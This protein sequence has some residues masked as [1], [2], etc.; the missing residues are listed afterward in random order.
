[1]PAVSEN[2]IS[3]IGGGPAGAVTASLLARKGFDVIVYEAGNRLG[4]KPCGKGIPSIGD[5]PV[6]VPQ[7][8]IVRKISGAELYVDGIK[9]FNIDKGLEGIIVDKGKLLE[10]LIVESGAEILY[11]SI[12]KPGRGFVRSGAKHVEISNGILAGGNFFYNG[13]T[14]NAFQ[15]RVKSRLFEDLNK[16]IIYF[17][18][19]LIGYYY[20]FPNHGDTADVGVGGFASFNMLKEKLD[21][22]IK[23]NEYVRGSRII[24]GEGAKIAVGGI[25]NSNIDGLIKIGEA[26]GFVYPLTGE[27]IRPSMIS[28]AIVAKAIIEGRDPVRDLLKAEVTKSISIQRKILSRVK[29]MTARRRADLLLSIPAEAHAMIALGKIDRKKLTLAL[30]K[31]PKLLAKI[32]GFL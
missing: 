32:L 16:L 29:S 8:T 3:I 4:L 10:S 12:Y 20:I 11:K 7:D 19:K 9:A 31:K 2:K 28:G 17:D 15:Y 21:H 5:L 18:T 22:F 24:R 23:V 1:M 25:N 30:A 13:E 6:R 27:G 14:I 26:A